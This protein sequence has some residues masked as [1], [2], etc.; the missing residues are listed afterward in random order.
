MP[1][2]LDQTNLMLGV[3]DRSICSLLTRLDVNSN[4]DAKF[5]LVVST[6]TLGDRELVRGAR[7][8][9]RIRVRAVHGRELDPSHLDVLVHEV[10]EARV[11]ELEPASRGGGGGRLSLR[12]HP[13]RGD[14]AA[15]RRPRHAQQEQVV[16]AAAGAAG[17]GRGDEVEAV[18][19][20]DEEGVA[21]G[22]LRGARPAVRGDGVLGE[23][24]RGAGE[25]ADGAA[26]RRARA[27]AGV[28]LTV[29]VR[30]PVAAAV[31]GVRAR[32]ADGV[33]HLLHGVAPLEPRWVTAHVAPP[34]RRQL[35]P[36]RRAHHVPHVALR[37]SCKD[38]R[39]DEII[40]NLLDLYYNYIHRV[41]DNGGTRDIE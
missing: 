29:V 12:A 25:A 20:V 1:N 34:A 8:R 2:E 30:R 3:D 18:A 28:A 5:I 40:L 26:A 36:A 21:R 27:L 14:G 39:S 19:E 13:D 23:R 17:G 4:S 38:F 15:E 31:R 33:H 16:S 32:H 22:G 9:Q 10:L 7:I 37:P 6:N 41:V 11:A 35:V 24:R